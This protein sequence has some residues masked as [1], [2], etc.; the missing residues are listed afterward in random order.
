MRIGSRSLL[1]RPVRDKSHYLFI[2][3]QYFL[4]TGEE[5]KIAVWWVYRSNTDFPKGEEELGRKLDQLSE[6]GVDILLP[7]IHEHRKM[8]YRSQLD[9]VEK[10]DLLSMVLSEARKRGIEV[11]P[12]VCPILSIGLDEER[13]RRS[14]RPLIAGRFCA[15]WPENREGGVKIAKDILN[16]H[17]VDG[18]HLD[19]IRYIDTGHSLRYPCQCEACSA[20]YLRTTGR[21]RIA[22]EDLENPG[23]LHKF[24]QFR[25]EHIRALTEEIRKITNS[26]GVQL[27]MAARANYFGSALVEGQDWV[28][29]ARDGLMD[30]ICPMNYST[31]REVHRRRLQEQMKLIGESVPI[32]DGIGRKS[33]AGEITPKQMIQQAE[34]AL[35]IGAKGIT[36]F[37][38]NA[39]TDED[40]AELRAFKKRME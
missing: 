23:I 16:N 34:D 12:V 21:E 10:Q 13:M 7:F 20:E 26:R 33:S 18:I 31:D 24:I 6:G 22:A 3:K 37:H 15:S 1:R 14:Y 36:I 5:M 28:Q 9:G 25:G 4:I 19:A 35:K 39:M 17:K 40:F 11:H 27:S 30:F 29:W 32:Y 38:L 2:L 8:W